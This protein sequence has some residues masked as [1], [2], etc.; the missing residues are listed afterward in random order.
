MRSAGILLPVTSLPSD[1][2]IGCFSKEAYEFADF[3]EAA[4]QSFWQILPTGPTGFGDSPYQALSVRAGNP[5]MIDLNKLVAEGLL[6]EKE[7]GD[8]CDGPIDYGRL[9]KERFKPLRLAFLRAKPGKDFEKFAEENAYWLDDYAFYSALK[10][11]S[12]GTERERRKIMQSE[13]KSERYRETLSEDIEFHKFLQYE[14][15]SQYRSLKKYVNSK[16]IKIIGDMPIYICSDSAEFS[17]NPELFQVDENSEPSAVAGCPPDEFSPDGQLWGNPLY[18]WDAHERD[19]FKWWIERIRYAFELYD[20]VRIDHFRGFDEYYSVPASSASAKYGE[21]K[22]APGKKLFEEAE[23]VLGRRKFIAE[24]LGFVTSSA[25]ELLRKCGFPGMKILQFA[26]DSCRNDGS[27]EHLPHNYEKNS[28]AY[29]GTHDN[30][31]ITSW[32]SGL[33][34]SS[35]LR[36][37]TYLC[38]LYTPDEKIN[39][40]LIGAIMRSSAELCVIPLQDYIGLGGEARINTPSTLGNNWRWRLKKSDL[41]PELAKK[42]LGITKMSGRCK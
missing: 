8:P 11:F 16:G 18:A 14:F 20:V 7:C 17:K 2:G 6:S 10:D 15:F 28:V 24:D 23:K 27:N 30:D 39:L 31:T 32:F 40:P 38:D 9:Y 19:G 34:E 42:I 25:K 5:Y 33:P 22:K 13:E 36:I 41:T 4:G 21:W 35:K 3:S 26:F 29:T 12:C 37:R 1:Y